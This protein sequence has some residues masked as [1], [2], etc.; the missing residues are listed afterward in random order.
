MKTGRVKIFF[1]LL[2]AALLAA[3]NG[4]TAAEAKTH[5]LKIHHFLSP[6]SI[7]HSRMLVPWAEKVMRESAG[8]LKVEVYPAMQLGGKP[9]Q[10]ADQARDGVVDMVWTLPGYTPGRFRKTEVFE[11]PFMHTTATATNMALID[12][13]DDFA[14]EFTDYQVIALHVHP[15]NSLHSH[16]PVNRV[17]DLAGTKIRTPTRTGAWAIESF[18]AVPIGAPVPKIPEM[19]SR[20]IVDSVMIPFEVMVPLKV[21]EMVDYHII[22]DDPRFT[23]INTSVFMFVMNKASFE[24]L[25][26]DLQQVIVD[27]SGVAIAR[28][29][30]EMWDDAENEGMAKA[31]ASGTVQVLPADETAA[32][33]EM[34]EGPVARRWVTEMAES[35]IDGRALIKK[36]RAAIARHD[37]D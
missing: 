2:L 22:L 33:R 18:G 3:A 4:A 5:T 8:R 13:A 29:L 28:W 30:G 11:L 23:R 35:G 27:N 14:D 19:L 32:L 17:I 26:A 20:K 6:M 10:L 12:M 7:T 36:A 1:P 24:R 16:E 15:G 9:P 31:R 25:P 34:T 21:D 37:G